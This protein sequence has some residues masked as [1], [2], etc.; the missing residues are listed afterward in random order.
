MHTVVCVLQGGW[1]YPQAPAAG[2]GL[3]GM[4][5]A[6]DAAHLNGT[7]PP[8]PQSPNRGCVV[9]YPANADSKLPS[10]LQLS[11]PFNRAQ[12]PYRMVKPT[13]IGVWV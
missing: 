4:E 10:T 8:A 3:S 5:A 11:I 6:A 12:N 9:P 7:E 13:S 1:L 2:H